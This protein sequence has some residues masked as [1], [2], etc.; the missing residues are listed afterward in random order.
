[1]T[2]GK[3]LKKEGK[4]G[5]VGAGWEVCKEGSKCRKGRKRGNQEKR[6]K[7]SERKEVEKG[8]QDI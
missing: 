2:W 6:G 5:K 3:W 8:I 7:R 1:M 4:E